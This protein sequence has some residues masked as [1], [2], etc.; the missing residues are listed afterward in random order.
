LNKTIIHHYNISQFSRPT[1]PSTEIPRSSQL[2]EYRGK[3][4]QEN[5]DL[6]KMATNIID[7]N[8]K[9]RSNIA[10]DFILL[11]FFETHKSHN[12]A[13]L[14]ITQNVRIKHR[15]DNRQQ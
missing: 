3:G 1:Q 4:H 10:G 7:I 6:M 12:A 2:S 13:R 9:L 14:A 8:C 11:S 15:A 5:Q